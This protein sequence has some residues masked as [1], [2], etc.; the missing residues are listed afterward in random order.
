MHAITYMDIC[1][2]HENIITKHFFST[3]HVS[4]VGVAKHNTF[5]HNIHLELHWKPMAPTLSPLLAPEVVVTTT[6]GAIS[7]D[8]VGVM[9]TAKSSVTMWPRY[10]CVV[11]FQVLRLNVMLA[12]SGHY[13]S[14]VSL[15]RHVFGWS[16]PWWQSFPLSSSVWLWL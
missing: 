12:P 8:K 15:P 1:H 13:D 2:V 10:V 11:I 16:W 5:L 6:C 3:W 9:T 7:V 4:P 14:R